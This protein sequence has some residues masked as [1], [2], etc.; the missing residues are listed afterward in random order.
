[1]SII[2][3]IPLVIYG[4]NE[5]EYGNAIHENENPKRDPKYY[6][7]EWAVKDLVL[8]GISAEELIKT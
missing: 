4:E 1:M 3:D 8:G 5:A 7:L 2:L 6:S